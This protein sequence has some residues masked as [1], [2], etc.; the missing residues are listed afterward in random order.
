MQQFQTALK[1]KEA[2]TEEGLT[3]KI[4][5]VEMTAYQ[6][7]S[8]QMAVL[9]SG[10][11]RFSSDTDKIATFIDFFAAVLDDQSQSYVVHRLLDREDPFGLKELSE[12]GQWMLEEWGGF[13]TQQPSGSQPSA[14]TTTARSKRTTTKRTSSASRGASG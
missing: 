11:G 7:D 10:F 2:Q 1:E 8:A 14:S 5:D 4:D 6:P 12:I 13:P 3:F 9:V